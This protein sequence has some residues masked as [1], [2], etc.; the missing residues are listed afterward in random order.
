MLDVLLR[1]KTVTVLITFFCDV[2]RGQGETCLSPQPCSGT[3][4]PSHTELHMACKHAKLGGNPVTPL[5]LPGILPLPSSLPVHLADPSSLLNLISDAVPGA[6]F[7]LLLP[8]AS[9]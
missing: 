7:P 1:V 9:G 3:W 5:P 4:C 8:L 2:G 6:Q